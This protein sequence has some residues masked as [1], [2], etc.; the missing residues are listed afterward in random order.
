MAQTTVSDFVMWAKHIH[1]DASIVDRILGLEAGEVLSLSVDGSP[2][3]WRKMA[4]GRDGRPTPGL[5]PVGATATI[6]R[7][8]YRSR[9][10]QLVSLTVA[11]GELAKSPALPIYP[12]LARNEAERQAALEALLA[13][14]RQG[15][16]SAGPYGPRE[17]LYDR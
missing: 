11:E 6:W 16:K 7:E 10:G 17:D 9:R 13:A 12:A 14:G 4:N 5:R 15:W 2:G 8:L 3:T 1:G